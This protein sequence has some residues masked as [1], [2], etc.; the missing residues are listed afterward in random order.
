ML[1]SLATKKDVHIP[2]TT[3]LFR[4]MDL[5]QDAEPSWYCIGLPTTP[6]VPVFGWTQ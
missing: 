2:A 6:T 1:R 3:D 4:E 5:D